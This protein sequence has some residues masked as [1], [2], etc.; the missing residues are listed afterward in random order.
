VSVQSVSAV[1]HP[2]ASRARSRGDDLEGVNW[3]FVCIVCGG[4]RCKETR[5]RRPRG[6][7][8]VKKHPGDGNMSVEDQSG[9]RLDSQVQDCMAMA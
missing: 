1:D 8:K 4:Q 7:S 9:V 3:G 5:L 2:G 6:S